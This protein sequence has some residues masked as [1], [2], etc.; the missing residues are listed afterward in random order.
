MIAKATL[1]TCVCL[2]WMHA[3]AQQTCASKWV[4]INDKGKLVYVADERG[5]TLPDF[6]K[7]GYYHGEKDIPVVPVVRMVSASDNAEQDI[8]QA[9][10]AV[11]KL[12][13]KNG[14]RGAV[15]LKAGTY[16][17]AGTLRIQASGIVLRGEGNNAKLVATGKGQRNL[18]AV[19]GAGSL[20]RTGNKIA[21]TD[22]YV[23]VGSRSFTVAT[24]KGLKVGDKI[25]VYRPAT[26]QWIT[27]LQMDRIEVRDSGTQ[28]WQPE[29]FNLSFERSITAINGK[30][31]VIDNPVV[32]AM[33]Q[34]Y[35]VSE[36]FTY[37]FNGRLENIGIEQLYCESAFAGDTDE[38]HG[39]NAITMSKVE[40]A[41]VKN[42]TARYF[43]YSCVNLS[44]SAKNVTVDSCSCLDAKSQITGG[45]RYSFN[46]D[47]QQ[48]LFMNCFAREGR[49]D[50]VTGARVCG[51]NVFYNCTAQKAH[52]DIG[53]H[54]RWACGTLYDNIV[55]DGDINIQDRG[56]WGTGH[57]W[58]GITQI[59]WNCT[60]AKA[61]IQDPWVSGKNYAFNLKAKRY[62][63]R[64]KGR[65]QSEWD[66]CVQLPAIVSLFMA[67]RNQY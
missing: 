24:T 32:M 11:S 35:G 6:S 45:R 40:N 63:G 53:P 64:L 60:A 59:V 5:N 50:Y 52:A 49:H 43:G 38:D 19:S 47:G 3:G 13:M 31:I 29:Q 41:W 51:P 28:Q 65:P 12:P 1:V 14:F 17:I 27:D 15:L 61:A 33:D 4:Q 54:H 58:V 8:Q 25:V 10:D 23:P 30:T 67:Q 7:V 62:E 42:V 37:A 66:T 34:R 36:I 21:I 20:Q 46:N 18:I 26:Q 48:N 22:A 55:T 44:S 2:L 16:N 9:I 39:W 56:N 57:G